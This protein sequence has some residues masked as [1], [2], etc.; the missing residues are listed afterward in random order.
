MTGAYGDLIQQVGAVCQQAWRQ[1][2]GVAQRCVVYLIVGVRLHPAGVGVVQAYIVL[3]VVW[4]PPGH[5]VILV[6]VVQL[7]PCVGL[8][9]SQAVPFFLPLGGVAGTEVEQAAALETGQVDLEAALRG[10]GLADEVVF[11]VEG[12]YELGVYAHFF[13]HGAGLHIAP[14]GQLHLVLLLLAVPIAGLEGHV[15]VVG[16]VPTVSL[17]GEDAVPGVADGA[18]VLAPFVQRFQIP[19]H[20][21]VSNAIQKSASREGFERCRTSVGINKRDVLLLAQ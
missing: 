16:V 19:A 4:Q 2:G 10:L 5:R 9:A 8:T 7:Y 6:V 14:C 11:Q 3:G 1:I 21:A 17:V 20:I 18:D 15:V 12:I 13:L